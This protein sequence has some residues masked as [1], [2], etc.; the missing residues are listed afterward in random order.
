MKYTKIIL[1]LL[2]FFTVTLVGSCTKNKGCMDPY[3]INYSP[4]AENDDDSCE[5]YG[6]VVFWLNR[7]P[8]LGNINIYVDDKYKGKIT[9]YV[10]VT[11]TAGGDCY[12]SGGLT[13]KLVPGTYN[14][15]AQGQTAKTWTREGVFK[16][17]GQQC[18]DVRVYY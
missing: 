18:T 14:Y 15:K 16:I 13:L 17:R 8:G 5:Y 10:G 2:A 12:G 3:A 4:D 6:N 9:M 11:N 1:V 7:D